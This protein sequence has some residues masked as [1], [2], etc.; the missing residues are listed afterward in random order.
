MKIREE[1][2][3]HWRDVLEDDTDSDMGGVA[4]QGETLGDFIENLFGAA[5]WR[6]ETT[7]GDINMVLADC[8]IKPIKQGAENER[9]N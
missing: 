2:L 7:L 8:G 5:D 6:P 1:I 3:E 4:F 9:K